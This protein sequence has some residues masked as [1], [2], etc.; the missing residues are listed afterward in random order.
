MVQELLRAADA[1][2]PAVRMKLAAEM[3]I[4]AAVILRACGV[5]VS[6]HRRKNR[7]VVAR[8]PARR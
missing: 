3:L 1:M 6:S 7:R 5:V 4:G 2:S 8:P